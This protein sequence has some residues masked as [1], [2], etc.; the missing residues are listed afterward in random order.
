M[1][2]PAGRWRRSWCYRGTAEAA[3][4]VLD[5]VVVAERRH[6]HRRWPPSG[7][8]PTI[9]RPA[10]PSARHLV[11]VPMLEHRRR[12]PGQRR[13]G[14]IDRLGAAC[15][16]LVLGSCSSRRTRAQAPRGSLGRRRRPSSAHARQVTRSSRTTFSSP[17]AGASR[18]ARLQ[19]RHPRPSAGEGSGSASCVPL[20]ASAL[21][22]RPGSST[23]R[24]E[25][26]DR[27]RGSFSSNS[28]CI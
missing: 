18:S 2:E 21:W 27:K 13:G 25:A 7:R 20:K 19:P 3:V 12:I 24:A 16:I 14:D 11:G 8:G 26:G 10:A 28:F 5:L 15:S 17:A 22:A 6:E 4:V 23:R 1:E 9:R